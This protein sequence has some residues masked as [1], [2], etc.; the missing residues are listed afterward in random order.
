METITRVTVRL[1]YSVLPVFHG[2]NFSLYNTKDQQCPPLQREQPVHPYA[3]LR[4]GTFLYLPLPGHS[5]PSL[6]INL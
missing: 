3:R 1:S 6:S 4:I 2:I 5:I